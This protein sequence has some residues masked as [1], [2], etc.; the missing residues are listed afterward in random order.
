[1]GVQFDEATRNFLIKGVLGT[2]AL[3]QIGRQAASMLLKAIPGLGSA[4]NATIAAALTAALG[5]AYIVLCIEYTRRQ[6][7]G[8]PMPDAEMLELLLSEFK[9]HYKRQHTPREPDAVDE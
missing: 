7:A 4:I 3:V 9:R 8:H 5:E 6:A 1:M 2:G